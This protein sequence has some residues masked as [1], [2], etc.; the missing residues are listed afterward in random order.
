MRIV[1][2]LSYVPDPLSGLVVQFVLDAEIPHTEP[3]ACEHWDLYT[4]C[5]RIVKAYLEV[6]TNGWFTPLFVI[7]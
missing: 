6:K 5:P 1:T 3:G 4:E 7:F 2:R